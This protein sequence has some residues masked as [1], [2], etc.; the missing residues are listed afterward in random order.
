[1]SEWVTTQTL[2]NFGGTFNSASGKVYVDGYHSMT[3]TV[4]LSK[5][6]AFRNF[7]AGN[8]VDSYLVASATLTQGSKTVAFGVGGKTSFYVP[9]DGRWSDWVSVADFSLPG[10]VT[11]TVAVANVAQ[12]LPVAPTNPTVPV[13]VGA[14]EYS[15]PYDSSADLQAPVVIGKTSNL[16]TEEEIYVEEQHPL[17][18][19]GNQFTIK[20]ST[21]LTRIESKPDDY[22][23]S[24]ERYGA[25]AIIVTFSDGTKVVIFFFR[26]AVGSAAQNGVKTSLKVTV[27]AGLTNWRLEVNRFFIW[28]GTA[29][30]S[31]HLYNDD[32]PSSPAIESWETPVANLRTGY[33]SHSTTFEP[34]GVTFYLSSWNQQY[35]NVTAH[36][37]SYADGIASIPREIPFVDKF[38]N[39]SNW[40]VLSWEDSGKIMFPRM[41][42]VSVGA[43][44]DHHIP[45]LPATFTLLIDANVRNATSL[46]SETPAF[47]SLYVGWEDCAVVIFYSADGIIAFLGGSLYIL[48]DR[49]TGRGQKYAFSVDAGDKRNIILKTY[50]QEGDSYALCSTVS[51]D[52]I[53]DVTSK[54]AI[55]GKTTVHFYTYG[56]SLEVSL[57]EFCIYPG[58]SENFDFTDLTEVTQSCELTV[59]TNPD[60]GDTLVLKGGEQGDIAFT[61]VDHY[62]NNQYEIQIGADT[63]E[64]ATNIATAINNYTLA[65]FAAEASTNTV[66]VTS[67]ISGEMTIEITGT[68]IS[69]GTI[70]SV[71]PGFLDEEVSAADSFTVTDGGK[72]IQ[73]NASAAD[74]TDCLMDG[75]TEQANASDFFDTPMA[76]MSES[77]SASDNIDGLIDYM[78][79]ET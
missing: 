67:H 36:L 63:S 30:A 68:G 73:E 52:G 76:E 23:A 3:Q 70:T 18:S 20:F 12:K 11:Y 61:F 13:P 60:P 74:E 51:G 34:P 28:Q 38:Y 31:W 43:I 78:G 9:K 41:S 55:A 1:M 17:D 42:E 7:F 66:I 40:E 50:I 15:Q 39:L 49:P 5:M 37:T 27:P 64:T 44:A 46:F 25:L 45:L 33:G 26:D 4:Y 58:A 54:P 14:I 22:L 69:A 75:L 77:V 10:Y 71:H 48:S 72:A 32:I 47:L 6:T 2:I 21:I 19:I 29:Y 59:D 56:E 35:N 57:K 65:E 62:P 79:D 53:V 24:P 8:G 16:N